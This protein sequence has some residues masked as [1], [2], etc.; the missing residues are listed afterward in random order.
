MSHCPSSVYNSQSQK[1]SV[2][3]VVNSVAPQP[4]KESNF[5][6]TIKEPSN[7]HRL[8]NHNVDQGVKSLA[9]NIGQFEKPPS[10][11]AKTHS[12]QTA[13]NEALLQHAVANGSLSDTHRRSENFCVSVTKELQ[14]QT[15]G[16][17]IR[18]KEALRLKLRQILGPTP[19]SFQQNLNVSSRQMMREQNA[20][21]DA[22]I[23][24]FEKPASSPAKTHSVQNAQNEALLVHDVARKRD[25]DNASQKNGNMSGTH[26]RS[27]NFSAVCNQARVSVTKEPQEQ[28]SGVEISSKEALRMNVSTHQMMRRQNAKV[29]RH[30]KLRQNSDTIETDS[31]NV[32][33]TTKRPVTRSLA[34]YKAPTAGRTRNFKS[35]SLFRDEKAKQCNSLSSSAKKHMPSQSCAVNRGCLTTDHTDGAKKSC[36]IKPGDFLLPLTGLKNIQPVVTGDE[37]STPAKELPLRSVTRPPPSHGCLN[38]NIELQD[39]E[40]PVLREK[41]EHHESFGFQTPA[42]LQEDRD[43]C[44]D[45]PLFKMTGFVLNSSPPHGSP[46]KAGPSI[47]EDKCLTVSSSATENDDNSDSSDGTAT[48]DDRYSNASDSEEK[49]ADDGLFTPGKGEPD[50]TEEVSSLKRAYME[51]VQTSSEIGLVEKPV[52]FWNKRHRSQDVDFDDVSPAFT[53]P[54]VGGKPDDIFMEASEENA[55]NGIARVISLLGLALEKVKSKMALAANRRCLDILMSASKEIHSQLQDVESQIQTDVRKLTCLKTLK[56]KHLETMLQEQQECLKVIHE[57]FMEEIHMYL[58]DCKGAAEGLEMQHIELKEALEAQKVSQ[59]KLVSQ[60]EAAVE[61]HI[62][63]AHRKMTSVCKMRQKK[64]QQLKFAVGECLKDVVLG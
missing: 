37:K 15:S 10:S 8:L 20:K 29:D 33:F 36:G 17:E 40:N 39:S 62:S 11:P 2:G 4:T 6:N 28:T 59:R 26:G 27:E 51:D 56:R 61:N 64:M 21:V 47:V 22:N 55:D 54:K 45:C 12:L 44:S 53:N 32:S 46:P 63:D 48:P 24:Q 43:D 42:A 16:E 34:R 19:F 3:I 50:G 25:A 52:F 9:A 35:K 13:R 7:A 1:I 49:D 58:Q 31:E 60:A 23:G 57:K 41:S 14:H 18:I 38:E 5:S 30:S